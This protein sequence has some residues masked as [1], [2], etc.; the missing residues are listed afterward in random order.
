MPMIYYTCDRVFQNFEQ[1]LLC[2]IL[3]YLYTV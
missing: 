2:Y 1:L 3:V